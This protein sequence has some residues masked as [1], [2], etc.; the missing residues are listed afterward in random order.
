MKT[1]NNQTLLYDEDC[2]MC[3]FYTAAFI[4]TK[5]LDTNGR[6]PFVTLT[7]AEANYI[8]MDRAKTKSH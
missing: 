2:P 1:L 6:K 4:K 8:D 3:T 5:M 7:D